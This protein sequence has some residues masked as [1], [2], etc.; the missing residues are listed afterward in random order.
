[1]AFT[2]EPLSLAS[3]LGEVLSSV[4][5]RVAVA[6][7]VPASG[8]FSM[9]SHVYVDG[10]RLLTLKGV[11]MGVGL[12]SVSS[13]MPLAFVGRLFD[14]TPFGVLSYPVARFMGFRPLSLPSQVVFCGRALSFGQ[15]ATVRPD[16]NTGRGFVTR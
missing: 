5:H 12:H 7:R 14:L 6:L 13:I 8:V 15:S 16:P 4:E 2:N 1:M 10:W 11:V 3:R 9:S